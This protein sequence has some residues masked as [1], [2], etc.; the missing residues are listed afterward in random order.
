[1]KFTAILAL[2]TLAASVTALP[3][4]MA[5]R[6]HGSYYQARD[7]LPSGRPYP[8]AAAP[9]AYPT[10][11]AE[12][13]E[14]TPALEFSAG[15]SGASDVYKRPTARQRREEIRARAQ[16]PAEI[17][18]REAEAEAEAEAEPEASPQADPEPEAE[19][20]EIL[21]DEASRSALLRRL[22]KAEEDAAERKADDYIRSFR[23]HRRSADFASY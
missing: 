12:V 6:S 5:Y 19:E 17:Y 3:L 21:L 11:A 8:R 16:P 14:V 1:M 15:D 10:A 9:E 20:E 4:E 7:V 23:F 13:P 2:T 22:I 18:E